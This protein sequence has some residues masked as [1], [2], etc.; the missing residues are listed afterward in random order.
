MRHNVDVATS[1]LY[2]NRPPR[3]ISRLCQGL[4][5]FTTEQHTGY[6]GKHRCTAFTYFK[7]T[8]L[9]IASKLY[10]GSQMTY[11]SLKTP[12]RKRNF[13]FIFQNFF[14]TWKPP[15]VSMRSLDTGSH[16]SRSTWMLLLSMVNIL[17]LSLYK[18]IIWRLLLH[19]TLSL[20]FS[21]IDFLC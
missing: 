15:V 4:Q 10:K 12:H 21:L 19:L 3:V 9:L 6:W 5:S 16:A 7:H 11:T 14:F 1:L 13:I 17:Q 2:E 20:T 8:F 18:R